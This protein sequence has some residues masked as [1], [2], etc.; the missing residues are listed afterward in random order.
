[1]DRDVDAGVDWEQCLCA[2]RYRYE[3]S[4]DVPRTK[5][6]AI[7]WEKLRVATG[8]RRDETWNLLGGHWDSGPRGFYHREC[9]QAYT[10]KKKL[11]QLRRQRTSTDAG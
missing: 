8:V 5:F 10:H 1:M 4:S 7:S 6:T 9:Y 2:C 11:D 3:D